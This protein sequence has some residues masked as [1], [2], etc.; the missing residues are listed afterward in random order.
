MLR[1]D[2]AGKIFDFAKRDGFKP[3]RALKAEAESADAAEKVEDA[4]LAH[5]SPHI[6]RQMDG[7]GGWARMA[8][9]AS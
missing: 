6:R 3:T 1:Q 4:Q 7:L 5:H 8:C 2:A 9:V